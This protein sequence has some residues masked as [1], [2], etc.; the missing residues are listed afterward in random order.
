MD[1]EFINAFYGTPLGTPG[2]V[3]TVLFLIF[4][5]VAST[6]CIFLLLFVKRS[7]I[8]TVS[9]RPKLFRFAYIGTCIVEGILI[10]I[11]LL[12]LTE[13]VFNQSYSKILSLLVVYISH[14]WAAGILGLLLLRFLDWS[15]TTKTI[16]FLIYAVIFSVIILLVLLTIPLLT[17]QFTNQPG[18][19]YPREYSSLIMGVITPSREIAFIYGLGNYALPLM[20]FS[21]WILTILL[22]KT[23]S[24]RIG[25]KA[26]W[27]IITIPLLYQVFSYII[28]DAN[29]ISDPSLI[30]IIYSRPFEFLLDVSYQVA[31]AFFAV[32][33]LIIGRKTKRK[34]LQYYL[35]ISSIGIISLFSSMQPGLPFYAAFPPFG[36]V[37]LL[38]LGLS[39]YLLLV[40]MLGA[41]IIVSRD[42]ELRREIFNVLGDQSEFLTKMGVAEM[43][44]ELERRVIF[45]ASKTKLAEEMKYHVQQEELDVKMLVEEVLGELHPKDSDRTSN[46]NE[47]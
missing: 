5:A 38:F 34:A 17:E 6:I 42:S 44:R 9:G 28:K 21:S 11:L 32:A 22:F 15:L 30:E 18:L 23:Y 4:T 16:S 33:F 12:I 41:S 46:K 24:K 40:G 1:S 2:D 29:I 3:H 13:A 39:S 47:T 36:L 8:Y 7:N 19:I 14:V 26:F 45:V 37:T 43:Q 25:Q 27:A 20:I 31:G 35:F 10:L